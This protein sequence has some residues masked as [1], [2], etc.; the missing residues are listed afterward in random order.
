MNFGGLLSGNTGMFGGPLSPGFNGGSNL[1]M[2]AG[3]LP[4]LMQRGQQVTNANNGAGSTG[5]APADPGFRDPMGGGFGALNGSI[6]LPPGGLIEALGMLGKR[7]PLVGSPMSL[8]PP[9]LRAPVPEI[10]LADEAAPGPNALTG[11][12]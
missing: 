6:G 9:S 8:T 10:P 4:L 1:G 5:A 2:F 3:L 11:M 12:W 7:K